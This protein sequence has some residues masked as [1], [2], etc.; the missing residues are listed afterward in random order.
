MRIVCSGSASSRGLFTKQRKV[1]SKVDFWCSSKI[2][3]DNVYKWEW[4]QQLPFN[5]LSV[6]IYDPKCQV[7]MF[8][9]ALELQIRMR[10]EL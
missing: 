5:V 9:C 7:V 4:L 10:N 6:M 2:N 3:K 8:C 1:S